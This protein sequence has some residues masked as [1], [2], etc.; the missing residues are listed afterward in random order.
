M[1]EVIHKIGSAGTSKVP[2]FLQVT[3]VDTA[4]LR[5]STLTWC[6]TSSP[7]SENAVMFNRMKLPNMA[8]LGGRAIVAIIVLAVFVDGANASE[9]PRSKSADATSVEAHHKADEKAEVDA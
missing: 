6:H 8:Y 2:L 4:S 1:A 3:Y 9:C 5:G 7:G